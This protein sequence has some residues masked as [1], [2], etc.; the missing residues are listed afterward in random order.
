MRLL[1][2][3][4]QIAVEGPYPYERKYF[5]Y[6]VR[7]ARL[8]DR[9]DWPDEEWSAD[10]LGSL[11]QENSA[12]LIGPPPWN[13]R[14]GFE[15]GPRWRAALRPSA[16]ASPGANS[17]AG[18]RWRPPG[19]SEARP[20]LQVLR[21]EAPQHPPGRPRRAPAPAPRRALARS[22]R[23][24]RLGS[25]V[26]RTPG[27]QLEA[28]RRRCGRGRRP[29]GAPGTSARSARGCSGSPR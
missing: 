21:R 4:P 9:P 23:L 18:R 6:L 16:C 7:W 14:R 26:Q 17:R 19:R 27:R 12:A 29:H 11:A 22:A 8:L 25:G 15:P 1:H 2:S 28:D 13:P 3:S 10:D 5:A 24:V 20:R